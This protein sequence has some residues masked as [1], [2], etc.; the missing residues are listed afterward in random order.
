MEG[1]K[2]D[3]IQAA[4]TPQIFLFETTMNQTIL[5][6]PDFVSARVDNAFLK[7]QQHEKLWGASGVEVRAIV[8]DLE[9]K[10][11]ASA[12]NV[13]LEWIYLRWN[14]AFDAGAR[15]L[16]DHWE[17]GYGDL[18]WRGL[19]PQRVMPWYFL[20]DDGLKTDAYG[21]KT[22][23]HSICFWRADAQGISL[24]LD[25][26]NGGSGVRLGKRVLDAARVVCREGLGHESAFEA[27]RAFCRM[28]CQSPLNPRQ[29][30]YGGNDWYYAY[31]N[32]S[33]ESILRDA[34]LIRSLAPRGENKPFMVIDDGWQICNRPSNG[35]PWHQPNRKFAAMS[36]LAAR[37]KAMEVRPGIWMRPLLTSENV[38][39]NWRFAA[40]RPGESDDRPLDPSV[41]E[42][43]EL[44]R[45]D[46]SRLR[47]WGFE[48]I[49]HDFSTYDIFA[50]WGVNMKNAMALDNW[51][52]A[53]RTRTSAEITLD[54]YRAI[55]EA[56][57]ESLVIGC[58]TIGHLAS[59]LVELQRT[60]DDTSGR[61]WERTRKYGINTLAFR[62]SQHDAFFAA[63]ADC[64][65]LT[66]LIPWDLNK[67]WLELLAKSG[68]PLFVSAAPEAVGIEQR[69]ALKE[70]FEYASQPQ[71]LGE[72]LDWLDTPCPRRW[73]LRGEI[74]EFD[75]LNDE[76]VA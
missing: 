15:F 22:G 59:G 55:R 70:A 29:P 19:V 60:G 28:M 73:K 3:A 41:P 58:N 67:Q 53:D 48:M 65:G 51:H 44:V 69:A 5:R 40:T 37:M 50:Q 9:V 14:A 8:S 32:N 27:A 4:V 72:P 54:L 66:D 56:A 6:A 21:V 16:G 46:I 12:P 35:G 20:V 17:R 38:P 13:A 62:A 47:E 68:T 76:G 2:H 7:L 52:F 36:A 42:A 61:E 24:S 1:A 34:D 74:V 64:V 57:G 31:G 11:E 43:L 63:D 33:D 23:A 18:E 39:D 26:R 71:P 49:K 45:R 10:V 30:V 75:W 25:V